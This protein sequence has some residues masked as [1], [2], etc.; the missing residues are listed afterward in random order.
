MSKN[1]TT[2]KRKNSRSLSESLQTSL[3][4]QHKKFKNLTWLEVLKK[5]EQCKKEG[6]DLKIFIKP[7][8][9]DF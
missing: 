9:G 1:K 2:S 7:S 8:G 3:D 4:D 6:K 5:L